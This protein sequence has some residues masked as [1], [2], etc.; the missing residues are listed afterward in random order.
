MPFEHEIFHSGNLNLLGK[1][2]V[3][4]A[5]RAVIMDGDSILLIYSPNGDE[6][7]FPG[8]GVEPGEAIDAALVR[9]VREEVGGVVRNIV[10]KLGDIVEYD[11]PRERHLDPFTMR[12]S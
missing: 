7:K 4:I 9:E 2:Y 5:A 10:R 11:K 8:G 3:R 1:A 12:S 6:Y